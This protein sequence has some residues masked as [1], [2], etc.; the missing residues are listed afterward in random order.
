MKADLKNQMES[1][2]IAAV[3][4]ASNENGDDTGTRVAFNDDT[5]IASAGSKRKRATSGSVGRFLAVNVSKRKR[6][7]NDI[8]N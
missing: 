3:Q 5:T 1:R 6:I 7:R 8:S 2:I 4:R